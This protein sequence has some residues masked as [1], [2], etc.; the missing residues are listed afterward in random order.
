M[1]V[2]RTEPTLGL[3]YRPASESDVR[4]TWAAAAITI[5]RLRACALCVHSQLKANGLHCQCPAVR[6]VGGQQPVHIVRAEGEAC[7]P[8]ARHLDM[9]AWS[10]Q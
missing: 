1:P 9:A 4:H 7:G 2:K 10:A 3:A 5:P 6:L 8:C